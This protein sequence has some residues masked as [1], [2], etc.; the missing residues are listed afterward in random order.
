MLDSFYIFYK[1]YFY[2]QHF[3]SEGS[4][5]HSPAFSSAKSRKPR[6]KSL[7]TV[8]KEDPPIVLPPVSA[9]V[10]PNLNRKA[11]PGVNAYLLRELHIL[12]TTHFLSPLFPGA[13]KI[14]KVQ[15]VLF[16]AKLI[17]QQSS[18]I[19]VK[20]LFDYMTLICAAGSSSQRVRETNGRISMTKTK[21]NCQTLFFLLIE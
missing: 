13:N 15:T 11:R 17:L 8:E 14:H 6:R 4:E 7:R 19:W 21:Q 16:P 12:P 5:R 1:F 10:R 2:F 20:K 3:T 18:S 9:A